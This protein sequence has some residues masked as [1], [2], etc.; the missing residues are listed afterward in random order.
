VCRHLRI[1][2]LILG[3][4]GCTSVR[5]DRVWPDRS[6]THLQVVTCL[7]DQKLENALFARDQQGNEVVVIG[8]WASLVNVEAVKAVAEASG[9]LAGALLRTFVL[10]VP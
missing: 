2:L 5:L 3:L 1:L 4:A 6:E 9:T 8:S 7:S 10:G